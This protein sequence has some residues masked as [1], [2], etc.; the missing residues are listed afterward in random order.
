MTRKQA[1]KSMK[2]LRAESKQ[3]KPT[4]SKDMAKHNNNDGANGDNFQVSN[5][6][7]KTNEDV[8]PR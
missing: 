6:D 2:A 4:S 3:A 5:N 7:E 1:I 8:D